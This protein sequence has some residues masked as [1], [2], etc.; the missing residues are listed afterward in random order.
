MVKQKILSKPVAKGN[1]KIF[2]NVP[3]GT[4]LDGQTKNIIK[5]SC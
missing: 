5:A 2:L 1:I 3:I 4:V